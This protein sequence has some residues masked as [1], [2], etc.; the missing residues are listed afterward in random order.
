MNAK[1]RR[2]MAEEKRKIERRLFQA[3]KADGAEPMLAATNIKYD[4]ADK[5]RAIGCGGIGAIHRLVTKLGLPN[6]IDDA[7][8]VFKVHKPYYESDHVLSIAYNALCG[9]QTLLDL[10]LRRNDRNFL[11]ALGAKSIPDPTTA[12]DFC[13]RFTPVNVAT[14]MDS[15]NEVR[16]EVWKRA[17]SEFNQGTAIIDADG[18]TV[19]TEGE[20]KEGMDISYDGIWGYGAL[21]VSLA[22]TGE[23]LY[24]LNRGANRPSHEGVVPVLD[25]AIESCRRGGFKS[26]RLRGDT[27]FAMTAEFDRWDKDGV[28]FVFGYDSR[29]NMIAWAESAPDDFYE[30]LVQRAKRATATTPRARP[31]NVKDRVVEERGFKVIEA[32][33]EAVVDFHYRP[34]RCSKEYR[35]VALRKN[36]VIKRRRRIEAR[37]VRY[38]F[39]ITND[40]DLTPHQIVDEARKRCNQEN[41]IAQLKSGVRA[42]H[43]P[44]NTLVA[45]WAYMVMASLAWSV[46]AWVALLLPISPRWAARHR[47]ER[48][49]ILR[50]EFRT[51]IAAFVHVA[52]QIILTGRR[53]IYRLLAWNSWQ[54]TFFRLLD[55]I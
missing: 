3:S 38:F 39:Y 29:K 43:A 49:R 44:V 7:L 42:L 13:R 40:W 15:I 28:H 2:K 36:L 1:L 5:T 27:D 47:D 11:D 30:E 14:L 33:D 22:N 9:G 48:E 46:K 41:L 16:L 10:E 35:V 55:A 52:A 20:C 32:E 45:N 53:I 23:P 37:E 21:V 8:H 12:G 19:P 24:V 54:P 26:I 6:R 50:M 18:T 4:L 34:T 31:E 51:F 17:G 25:R